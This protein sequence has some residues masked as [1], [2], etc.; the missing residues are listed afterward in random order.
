MM[1]RLLCCFKIGAA[2]PAPASA[3]AAPSA[4][5][6]GDD[7][8]DELRGVEWNPA[9]IRNSALR[10]SSSPATKR[11]GLYVTD[12]PCRVVKVYDGDSVTLLWRDERGSL[13]WLFANTR[14]YGIDTP[15][16]RGGT[17]QT[18]EQ[19]QV[20]KSMLS[21]LIMDEVLTFS[22]TGPTGLDKYGRPLVVIKPCPRRSS[23]RVRETVG[24]FASVNEWILHSLPGC[25]P[26]FGGT[27]DGEVGWKVVGC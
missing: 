8:V 20:C 15:E 21:S 4:A 25:K 6:V 12:R 5:Q 10:G 18:R 9:S 1:R 2:A 27:K 13:G 3:S 17:E 16:M 7:L 26:Y 14:L 11:F 24:N 22:T 19:A 23:S